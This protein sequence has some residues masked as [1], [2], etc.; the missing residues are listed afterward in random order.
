[1][2]VCY[3]Q[4]HKLDAI[5]Y[6]VRSLA[7]GNPVVTARESMATLFEETNKKV[8]YNISYR[9]ACAQ[10]VD[11]LRITRRHCCSVTRV[12]VAGGGGVR[13]EEEGKQGERH[14]S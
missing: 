12:Y 5:Y 14:T 8:R 10:F 3:L 9:S 13:E 2:D 1:V 7:T 11:N 4:K 6:Y